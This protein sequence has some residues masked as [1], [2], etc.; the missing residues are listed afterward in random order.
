MI[1]KRMRR[2]VPALSLCLFSLTACK[3][4]VGSLAYNAMHRVTRPLTSEPLDYLP[5]PDLK[6]WAALPGPMLEV[7]AGRLVPRSLFITDAELPKG[8]PKAKRPSSGISGRAG[9]VMGMVTSLLAIAAGTHPDDKLG[10]IDDTR[11]QLAL[12]E[13]PFVLLQGEELVY[14]KQEKQ[15]WPRLARA[16]KRSKITVITKDGTFFGIAQRIHFRSSSSEVVLEGDPT[17]QSGQQHIKG[18]KPDAVMVL[19]FAKR[20]VLVNGP[21]VEKK[22]FR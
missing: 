15:M 14:V 10:S 3:M 6:Q 19:D 1:W 21:V 11:R 2:V 13:F 22:L 16:E 9:D 4:H 5:Y 8:A 17:V 20:R 7:Q 18:A 12:N